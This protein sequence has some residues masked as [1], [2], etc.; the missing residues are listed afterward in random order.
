MCVVSNTGDYWGQRLPKE[1]PWIQPLIPWET[2]PTTNPLM[3][4][5]PVRP[6]PKPAPSQEEF[7][8]LK[9]EVEIMKELLERAK[10]YDEENGEKECEVEEKMEKL[11]AIAAIVGID[12]NDVIKPKTL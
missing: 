3:P 9:K 2:S 12:L 7:D 5:N 8:A 4:Q 6:I 1:Y 10:K 11:R